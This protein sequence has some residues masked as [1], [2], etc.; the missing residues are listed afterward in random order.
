MT[1]Y[2]TRG[3]ELGWLSAQVVPWL[4]A[5][6]KPNDLIVYDAPFAALFYNIGCLIREGR[7]I[8]FVPDMIGPGLRKMVNI[9]VQ[10][11]VPVLDVALEPVSY[12]NPNVK[13]RSEIV[14]HCRAISKCPE[15]NW[16]KRK[17]EELVERLPFKP[18][19]IGA[20][21]DY[22]PSSSDAALGQPLFAVFADL[23][24]ARVVVGASSGPMHIA[25]MCKAPVVTWSGNAKKDQPRYLKE[26]NHFD[27]YTKFVAPT[28]NPT[29]DQVHKAIMEA[30]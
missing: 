7:P 26:W 11:S 12:R 13:C 16:S 24:E 9:K 4:R 1:M 19:V 30:F 29:V 25:Q 6:V 22:A 17:W 27:T 8:D 5:V 14:L 23:S 18:M 2:D 10:N 15:R 21:D 3:T 20:V 28:W